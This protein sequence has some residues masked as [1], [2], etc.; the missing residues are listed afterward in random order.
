VFL[1][2][3]C[4]GALIIGALTIRATHKASKAP[5]GRHMPLTNPYRIGAYVLITEDIQRPDMSFYGTVL[6][7]A[8]GMCTVR[9]A[10]AP[11]APVTVPRE[12]VYPGATIL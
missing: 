10:A 11:Y 12:Y 4:A 3:G 1:I 5:T 2:I 7:M 9:E 8:G 6:S